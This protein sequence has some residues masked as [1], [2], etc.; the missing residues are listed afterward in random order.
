MWADLWPC[1]KAQIATNLRAEEYE[2]DLDGIEDK[3][4]NSNLSIRILP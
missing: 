2:M 4:S 3:K 1:N